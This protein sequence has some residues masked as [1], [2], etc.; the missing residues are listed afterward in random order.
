MFRKLTIALVAD[1]LLGAQ[2]KSAESVHLE[3]CGDLSDP[4][5]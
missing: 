1:T 5:F 2:E 4:D 3:P